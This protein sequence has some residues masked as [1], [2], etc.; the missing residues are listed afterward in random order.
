[1]DFYKIKTRET[2]DRETKKDVIEV[3]PDF[4]VTRTKDLMVRGKGFYA[5][6]DEKEGLWSTDEY[7][8][9]RLVDADLKK[10]AKELQDQNVGRIVIKY[11]GNYSTGLWTKFRS[12]MRDL[13]DNA[14]QLDETLTFAN[15]EV[16]KDDYVSKRLVYELSEGSVESYDELIGTLYVPDERRKIEWAIGAV[17]AGDAR[18]IQKF[19]VLYGPAGAGKSTVLNIIQKL[20]AG[21]YTTFEA[22]ALTTSGNAFAT[23]VFRDN[24]LVAIQHDGDL[25]RIEDNTK[26]NSIVSHEEMTMNEKFKASYTA[27]INA[28]PFMGTNKAVKITDAKSGLIRRLIDVQPSGNRVSPQKY[29]VLYSQID[30]E[31]GAIAWYCLQVYRSLGKDYYS[32]YRPTEM[33]L[34]TDVF[35]NF[36]EYYY[37]IF[38]EQNGIALQQ[39]YTLYKQ[40]CQ[41]AL[42]EYKLPQYRFREELKNYFR[43]FQ[44]RIEIDGVRLRSY[45]SGFITDGFE[46][47]I[48]EEEPM[49][50]VLDCDISL[51]DEMLKDCPA[52]YSKA[53]GTPTKYW[54]DKERMIDGVMKKPD[55][56]RVC[57]TV[58]SDIDTSREHYTKPPEN[59][60]VIDF[61]LKD[62]DGNKSAE[63]N[64]KAASE[65]PPTYAEFS[66]GGAGV[67][68]HYIYA[69]DVHQLSRIYGEGIEIKIFTGDASLR[70]R[71]SKCNDIQ[72]ATISSGLPLKEKKMISNE[73]LKS[74]RGLRSLIE[75]N[76]RKEIHQGTKPSMDFIH[77]ILEDA[78]SSGL[79]YDVSDLQPRLMAFA[80]GS[81]NQATYCLKLLQQM[82]LASEVVDDEPTEAPSDDRLAFYDVEV[83]PNLLLINWKFEDSPTV[84][85]MINPSPEAVAELTKLK[86]VGFNNRRYDNHILHARI[87]GYNNQQIFELSSKIINKSPNAMF[88]VAYNLSYVDVYDYASKKQGLKK[89][90]IELG[91]KHM[92]L[93]LPWDQPVPEERW[94]EVSEY[95][96]NDVISTEAVH[97]ARKDDFKARQILA[98][99]SGLPVN[100]TTNNHTTRI[101]LDGQRNVKDQYVY[102][103]LATGKRT[104][105]K[106]DHIKF[107]GYEMVL[108]KSTYRGEEVSE[109]GLVRA[110]PGMYYHVGVFDV[111]SMHPTSAIE[112][113]IFGPFTK[114]FKAL[115]DARIAIKRG[116]FDRA[117]KMFDGK[118]EPYLDSPESAEPLSYALKIAANSVYGL[119]AA[120]F[121][122]PLRDPRNKDN[123]VAKRGALFML[124][125]MYYLEAG[126]YEVIHIKTDSVKIAN[127]DDKV[128]D[129]I[130]EFGRDY[131]YD[132]EHEVTY[133]KMCLVNNAV[134]IA[135]TE[136]GRKPPEWKAVGA[137][138][139]HPYVFKKLFT[140][141]PIEHS[142]LCETKTVTTAMYLDFADNLDIPMALDEGT[143]SVRFVGRAGSFVPVTKD[144]GYLLREK[145]GDVS[146][147]TGA[148]G[149]KWREAENV[150]AADAWD[151]VD[152]TYF[153]SLADDAFDQIAK[154]G[155]PEQFLED[156]WSRD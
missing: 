98:E 156:S 141:E 57:N 68:L 147:V 53:D 120:S 132:F 130:M 123:I 144:G 78:Y 100:E 126:G 37:E 150:E 114:N 62:E 121:D 117:K 12:Y 140:H 125:L 127:M 136:Q 24:P 133:E 102:T 124:D 18:F 83:F 63:L 40:Y 148:K 49:S 32:G 23:E 82:K 4:Q 91:L 119:T 101:I 47:Q 142:D 3:Y 31:L 55:P 143:S 2:K 58:L 14:H 9:Q 64:L 10:F 113:D 79:V 96:D 7:T 25:S 112:M 146:Y 29:Q 111:V 35:F 77:K 139:Q 134:F 69:G 16:R 80:M 88:G 34:E 67:H 97:K 115:L 42:I 90:Q 60:I 92:E 50:L 135:K 84:V 129:L 56:S 20:F 19:V 6:W 13:S 107:P 93:G 81:T 17:V 33:M 145:D 70:R 45:Y 155:D 39:A 99:I 118:L 122:H 44:D 109:G 131:G 110:K 54:T 87:M 154:Y 151:T 74:E 48:V 86:L 27:R 46:P 8:V 152:Y 51:I 116:E 52:Q 61:D 66:K 71:V 72:V 149:Y 94:Q 128:G 38:A 138:F 22:K 28:F 21:Y 41:E 5:V 43:D 11:L 103:D 95:C 59:H 85:R 15:T 75:R 30:F 153:N 104:D 65:W 105:G 36:I 26:L 106:V 1:M 137:E 76:L 73:T 108:G 89:W